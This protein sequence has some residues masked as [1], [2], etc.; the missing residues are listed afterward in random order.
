VASNPFLD[1]RRGDWLMKYRPDST[2][3]WVRVV[4]G[5]QPGW[6]K[7]GRIPKKPPQFILD[8]H[9]EFAE[10]EWRAKSGLAPAPPRVASLGAFLDSYLESHALSARPGSTAILRRQVDYFKAFAEER[11]IATVQG[12]TKAHCRAYLDRRI[13]TVSQATLRTERGY[14]VG[15]WTRAV[16]DGLIAASPWQGLALPGKPVEDSETF[17]TSSEIARIVAACTKPWQAD[18]VLLLANTGLRVSSALLMRW[19]WV[20]WSA[21][22][23]RLPV[24]VEGVKTAYTHALNRVARAVLERRPGMARGEGLCFPRPGGPGPVSYATTKGFFARA[25]GRAKVPAGTLHDLRHSYGR[26]LAMEGVP[27]TVIKSQLGHSTLEMTER[28]CRTNEVHA[29]RATG[30][31]GVGEDT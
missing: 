5:R 16:E 12:A 20:D 24:D 27:V 21:G 14:L 19:D 25:V 26:A 22:T 11:G 15:A 4:L 18:F 2:G 6:A 7:G 9:R 3:P 8:R 29:A 23:I 30:D 13:A 31:F 28:Y 1:P 10:I 17:W